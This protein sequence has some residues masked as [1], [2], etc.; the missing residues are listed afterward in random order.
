VSGMSRVYV[1]DV[2]VTVEAQRRRLAVI[3]ARHGAGPGPGH[4]AFTAAA[5]GVA[6]LLDRAGKAAA[7]KD[8]V[9]GWW[10]RCWRG[11][12]LETAYP[13]LHAAQVLMVDLYDDA[14]VRAALPAA[15]AGVHENLD[16][17]DPRRIGVTE[18]S[19]HDTPASRRGALRLALDAGYRA[20]DHN[21]SR[22]RTFRN[23]L[24]IGFALLTLLTVL[25]TAVVFRHPGFV[26]LCFENTSP[27]AGAEVRPVE[28]TAPA[29]SATGPVTQATVAAELTRSC[30]TGASFD[31]APSGW[32]IVLIVL[33]G[34][35]GGA[36]SSAV[37][38]RSLPVKS[39]PYG[40]S[41]VL[42]AFKLPSGAVA[43]V[44]GILAIE[45][46]FVPGL[47]ALDSQSQILA[48]AVILGYAQQLATGFLDRRAGGLSRT[49]PVPGAGKAE[50]PP[51]PA[52]EDD[53]PHDPEAP[54]SETPDPAASGSG[55]RPAERDDDR[56]GERDD[57]DRDGLR[58][59]DRAGERD[60]DPA[61]A[62]RRT[63]GAGDDLEAV[64]GRP[65]PAGV[66]PARTP[67]SPGSARTPPSRV[68]PPTA[69][70]DT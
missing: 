67:S 21:H 48:Y 20:G 5:D 63:G 57:D 46:G 39:S 28:V 33:L 13:Y 37:A 35:I 18:L 1:G 65:A 62:W 68:R 44:I 14:D 64:P 66:P 40:V 55:A 42:C 51:A 27:V 58:D 15:V 47:S 17:D 45:A 56:P 9:F 50:A 12:H 23:G 4:P 25:F 49:E 60:D 32:D 70:A 34:L 8:P 69:P 11:R 30:P 3:R 10:D 52:A 43:A 59:D 6:D 29:G 54:T 2:L 41:F 16:R 36:L 22:Q 31:R 7:G 38:L 19:R 24:L 61:P 26:P 53:A